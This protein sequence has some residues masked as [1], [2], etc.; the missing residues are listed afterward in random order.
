[1]GTFIT[2]LP[3]ASYKTA[4]IGIVL[5]IQYYLNDR[6]EHKQRFQYD[7]FRPGVWTRF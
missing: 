2:E 6:I 1:M 4:I 3:L 5:S 7:E